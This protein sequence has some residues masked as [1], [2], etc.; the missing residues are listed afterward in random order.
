MRKPAAQA[1]TLGTILQEIEDHHWQSLL[2]VEADVQLTPSTRVQ[3]VERDKDTREPLQPVDPALRR[4]LSVSDVRDIVINAMQQVPNATVG[5]LVEAL[6]YY[7][8][9]DAFIDFAAMRGASSRK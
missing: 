6:Q 2:F 8:S 5:Q 7:V 9:K 1:K 4:L 3:V